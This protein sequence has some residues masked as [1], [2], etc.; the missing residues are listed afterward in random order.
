MVAGSATGAHDPELV[1]RGAPLVERLAAVLSASSPR[2]SVEE[3]A[4]HGHVGLMEA[5]SRYDAKDEVPFEA[6]AR[7]RIRG[8][9]IDGIRREAPHVRGLGSGFRAAAEYFEAPREAVDV[10]SADELARAQLDEM[11]DGYLA[12]CFAA[13]SAGAARG[14]EDEL[15][16]RATLA[17]A[18]AA[19]A[20]ALDEL[21][22][23]G[24]ELVR[25][26]YLEEMEL[27]HV[28]EQ[29][30]IPYRSAKRYHATVIGRLARALRRR[31]ITGA[32]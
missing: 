23:R 9:I 3:L 18:A 31:G 2:F 13:Y 15:A 30:G 1:R 11:A 14:D 28:A 10:F 19:L 32:P 5:A 8:A 12:S 20:A 7:P 17:R 27:V 4:S 21:D 24:R 25:L 22:D 26:R 6:F 16:H 29:M